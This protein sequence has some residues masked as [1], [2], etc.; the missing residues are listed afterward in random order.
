M[1]ERSGKPTTGKLRAVTGLLLA[2]VVLT[3]LAALSS[4]TL[5]LLAWQRRQVPGALFF[6]ATMVGATVWCASYV[7]ELASLSLSSK[8]IWA[9]LAYLGV[10]TVPPSWLLFCLFYT[11]KLRR[12]AT[13]TILV[14]YLV[15]LATVLFAMLSTA[16]PLVWSTASITT[17]DGVRMLVVDHGLWFWVHTAYSYACLAGGSVVLLVS[18]L[19]HV[20]PLTSQG[21]T[22]V[23]AVSLP[24]LMNAFTIFHVIPSGFLEPLRTLDLTPPTFVASGILV[25][26]GLWR[27]QVFDVFPALVPVARDAVFL[28]LQD[29]VLVVDGHGRVL[30][31]NRAAEELLSRSG[32]SVVGASL[33]ALVDDAS[34]AHEALSDLG[35]VGRQRLEMILSGSE[36]EQRHVE[37]AISSHGSS[38]HADGHVLVM[39]DITERVTTTQ[40]LRA[41]GQRLRV[42]FDQ[43]PISVMVFDRHLVVTECNDGFAKMVR[44]AQ[45]DLIGHDLTS[46]E[47]S[48][49]LPFY[50]AALRGETS[51]YNGPY[52]L[53]PSGVEVWLQGEVS[54]LRDDAGETTGGIGVLRDMTDSKR[55]EELIERLAFNDTVTGLPN[56]TLFRDRLRQV[57][58]QA[59]RSVSNP[60]VAFVDLDRFAAVNESI[61]HAAADRLLQAVGE[62]LRASARGEDTIARWAGDEFAVLMPGLAGGDDSFAVAR[63]LTECFAKPWLIDG[64][65][66]WL[67]ASIGL[68]VYP[69]DGDDAQGLLKNAETAMHGAKKLGGGCHQFYAP[70]MNGRVDDRL[71]LTSG[72]HRALEEGE[73]VVYYQPQVDLA[74]MCTIGCEALVRWNHPERGLVAPD[75][76]IPLAEETGL[77]QPLGEWVLREACSQ[78]AAWE[79]TYRNGIRV[80][81][82]LSARQFQQRGLAQMVAD[83]LAQTGLPPHLLELEVTETSIMADPEAA[84]RTLAE[85]AV[86]GVTVALDDFGTGYSSLTRL[87]QLPIDRLKIDRSFVSR[88]PGDADDCA[89]AVTVIDLARNLGLQVIAEGVET[90]EQVSF[91][92]AK[93]CTEVQGYL[94]GK[95]EPA[96]NFTL[97]PAA[98]AVGSPSLGG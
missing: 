57:L 1:T 18:I 54:P 20:R 46:A 97:V 75:L 21:F 88:L 10:A 41:S 71:A 73:F 61:G 30:N 62:R 70:T 52:T 24:W 48:S 79:R 95:P 81:V 25:A 56:R 80:A 85:I 19:R 86:M 33:A 34:P 26:I 51:N 8:M 77:M 27:L 47:D 16:V 74:T 43:S 87:R 91:L 84:A 98:D 39:R 2:F 11:G 78:G 40:A 90:W 55:A 96:A 58:A 68:V 59:A 35:A 15:P 72:L 67:T 3:V 65:E 17:S 42:L 6:S 38:R 49:L 5:A 4:A 53:S 31:A 82:N 93:G 28:E 13:A 63:H 94:F 60:I 50:R 12:R 23:L 22:F 14:F 37:I 69:S 83:A 45:D 7:G 89:M 36:G 29:G 9:R 32:K 44:M 64:H 76:F 66:L 92:R